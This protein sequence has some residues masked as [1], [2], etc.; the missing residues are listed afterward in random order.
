MLSSRNDDPLRREA[1]LAVRMVRPSRAG[2]V[3]RRIADLRIR[4]HAHDG[5]LASQKSPQRVPDLASHVL[6]RPDRDSAALAALTGTGITRRMLRFRC[7]RESAQ[8]NT[9]RAGLGI[10]ALQAGIARVSPDLR[11]V[12]PDRIS[13]RHECW[14]AIHEDLRINARMRTVTD[15]LAENLPRALTGYGWTGARRL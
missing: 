8:V 9:I 12:L 2:L 14:V 4:L 11:P 13:L 6:I 1:D 5:Y 3:A 7:D 15:H 10:G